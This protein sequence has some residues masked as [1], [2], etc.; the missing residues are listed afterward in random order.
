[1]PRVSAARLAETVVASLLNWLADCGCLVAAI[2]AVSGHVPWSGILVIYGMTQIAENLP[3]T[4]GGI[5][6]VESTLSLMLV[7]YGMSMD[8]AV[9]AV[10][11]YRIISFWILVALGWLA[12][13]GLVLERRRALSRR[14]PVEAAGSQ[15]VAGSIA[16]GGPSPGSLPRRWC[17]SVPLRR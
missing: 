11:L 2:L 15:L 17:F 13:A 3:I 6:V 4:P 10:L 12:A 1:M 5:G 16:P 9:A 14:V 7:A 8:T